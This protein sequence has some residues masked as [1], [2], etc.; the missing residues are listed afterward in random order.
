MSFLKARQRS[1]TA[2]DQGRKRATSPSERACGSPSPG[3]SASTLSSQAWGSRPLALAVSTSE[4]THAEASTPARVSHS[5]R[6]FLPVANALQRVFHN[7]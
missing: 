6:F 7:N 1:G 2:S 3:I 4:Y 5:L